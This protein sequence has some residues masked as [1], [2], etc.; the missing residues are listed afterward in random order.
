[1]RTRVLIGIALSLALAAHAADDGGGQGVPGAPAGEAVAAEPPSEADDLGLPAAVSEHFR[2]AEEAARGG[3]A[4]AFREAIVAA[5]GRMGN[6]TISPDGSKAFVGTGDKFDEYWDADMWEEP[7]LY[8][9][10]DRGLVSYKIKKAS[11]AN[12]VWSADSRYCAFYASMEGQPL[13]LYVTDTKAGEDV[14]LGH[15]GLRD[16]GDCF[17][18]EGRY[19]AWLSYDERPGEPPLWFPGVRAYD[20][21][22]GKEVELLKA[23]MSTLEPYR[24]SAHGG[25]VKLVPAGKV[26]ESLTD[27]DLYKDYDG[28]YVDCRVFG[29]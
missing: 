11:Y 8:F 3:D 7:V 27:C 16:G 28:V 23:D 29:M 25:R 6:Y 15:V 19:L 4:A 24:G 20:L 12:A 17:V 21:E 9:E 26:P 18:F 22:R 10:L 13:L 2:A 14:A 5:G 1:M